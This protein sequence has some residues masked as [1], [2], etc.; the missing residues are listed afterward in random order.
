MDTDSRLA[1]FAE[2]VDS[3]SFSAVARR[4][5]STRANV[6]RQIA[7]LEAE[8]GARLLNRSTRSM[9]ATDLGLRVYERAQRIREQLRE[10]AEMAEDAH[11]AV[12]G[13][14]R[15][16]SVVHFGR[17]YVQPVALDFVREHPEV[18]IDLRLDDRVE[19]VVGEGFDLAVRVGR[20]AD[21]SLITR[22]IADV[23]V[24]ICASPSL[25]SVQREPGHPSELAELECVVYASDQVVVDRWQYTEAGIVD[26]V[27][28]K[29]RYRV[30]HGELLIEAVERGLGFA[31]LPRF[32]AADALRTG[33]LVQVL[34][35][36]P[37][38][39]YAPLHAVYPA[40]EYLPR[41]TRAF[42]DRLL[43]H[44]GEPPRWLAP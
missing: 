24:V 40:R 4:Q 12:R 26:V 14:L 17:H 18:Q 34:A 42:L 37:L 13:E 28:V 44:V 41:K 22:R 16:T 35:Q 7:Q 6:A 23:D 20:S 25:L 9:S 39:P 10:V 38:P 36:Y 31:L 3:G 30:N 5:R 1:L 43:A 11:D 2:V 29:S 33:R 8:L 27:Q 19:D 21:S 15:I 32:L